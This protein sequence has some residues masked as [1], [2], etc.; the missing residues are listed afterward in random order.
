MDMQQTAL[1]QAVRPRFDLLAWEREGHVA[2]RAIFAVCGTCLTG[3]SYLFLNV[4]VEWSPDVPM[5]GQVFVVLLCGTLLGRRYGV[6][7]QVLYIGAGAAGVRWLLGGFATVGYLVGF[8][9][10]AYFL[11]MMTRRSP[12]ARTMHGQLVLMLVAV[13]I[14]YL[15]GV[16][17]LVAITPHN[18]VQA[19]AV[20]IA[21]FIPFDLLKVVAAAAITSRILRV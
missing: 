13:G 3:L 5:T 7:S 17:G 16:V 4:R 20:G 21:P 11:G 1:K 14:I 6:L 8:V 12:W 2:T 18:L 10:A 15:C 19:I 9:A